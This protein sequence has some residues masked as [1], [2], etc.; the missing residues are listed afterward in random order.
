M[1]RVSARGHRE[2]G[3]GPGFRFSVASCATHALA[4]TVYPPGWVPY[5]RAAVS[6]RSPE[7]FPVQGSGTAGTFVSA[8]EDAA[9]GIHWAR[10]AAEPGQ[11]VQRTQGRWL[12]WTARLLGLSGS[13]VERTRERLSTILA[14]PLLLIKEAAE[15][16]AQGG[17]AER[18]EAVMGVW[19]ARGLRGQTLDALLHA[20]Q[21]TG[22]W[23]RG[24]RWDPGVRARVRNCF[25]AGCTSCS[26]NTA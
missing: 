5:G 17:W 14:V 3:W 23:G 16:Y 21:L 26:A 15:A 13:V 2:R 1:C 7:G 9:H 25:Y 22:L 12:E 18:G 10:S 6:V 4:F 19:K 20:G 24:S 8:A 11:P